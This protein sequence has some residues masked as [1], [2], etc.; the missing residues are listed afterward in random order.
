[1]ASAS[2]PAGWLFFRL[3]GQSLVVTAFTGTES[4]LFIRLVCIST[5]ADIPGLKGNFPL[6]NPIARSA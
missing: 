4:T 3:S 5:D 2:P 1:M 6:P